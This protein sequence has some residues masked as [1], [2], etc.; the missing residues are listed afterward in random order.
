MSYEKGGREGK[1]VVVSMELKK[2]AGGRKIANVKY[3]QEGKVQ[4]SNILLHTSE[5]ASMKEVVIMCWNS[6]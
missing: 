5:Y 4:S 6:V 2:E 3:R 1:D